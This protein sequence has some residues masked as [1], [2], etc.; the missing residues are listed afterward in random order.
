[1]LGY[2]VY[3]TSH[4]LR[5]WKDAGRLSFLVHHLTA[6]ASVVLGIYG[7]RLAVFGMATQV[8]SPFCISVLGIK[9]KQNSDFFRS[10]L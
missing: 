8:C 7:G 4:L 2:L 5:T 6:L 9:A 10:N 1:M 3:D